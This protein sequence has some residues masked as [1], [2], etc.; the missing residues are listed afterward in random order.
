M[1]IKDKTVLQ[2]LGSSGFG[3]GANVGNVDVLDGKIVR[4]RP[5]HY[6]DYYTPEELNE[7]KIEARGKTLKPGTKTLLPPFHLAYKH[8][9]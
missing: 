4:I 7:W 8:R 6:D 3:G 9:A 2:N 5:F 1:K